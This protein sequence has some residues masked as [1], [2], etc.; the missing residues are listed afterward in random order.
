[1][2]RAAAVDTFDPALQA[3]AN[4]VRLLREETKKILQAN[5]LTAAMLDVY[6]QN[7]R[8]IFNRLRFYLRNGDCAPDDIRFLMSGAIEQDGVLLQQLRGKIARSAKDL[9]GLE[10]KKI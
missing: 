8:A 6:D 9:L 7:R 2:R 10:R 5:P 4:D 3:A 1:M